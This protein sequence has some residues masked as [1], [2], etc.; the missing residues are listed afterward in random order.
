MHMF[1][2]LPVLSSKAISADDYDIDTI[3]QGLDGNDYIVCDTTPRTWQLFHDNTSCAQED[4]PLEI[5]H[6]VIK[7][8]IGNDPKLK[9]KKG[10]PAKVIDSNTV[11]TINN[12]IEEKTNNN[13]DKKTKPDKT[14]TDKTKTDKT[15]NDTTATDT[16]A[17]ATTATATPVQPKARG[18]P[19]KTNNPKNTKPR[20]PTAYNIFLQKTLKE[21][22]NLH[23]EV[24]N[25]ERMK[26]ASELWHKFKES[27]D[28]S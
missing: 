22:G 14:K 15:K 20:L 13:T 2:I 23:P 11:S 24:N 5:Y 27:E 1:T 9:K 7:N 18:R 19:R 4:T 12:K 28:A 16:T 3:C 8:D 21:L 10:R 6:F 17:T 26:M 25:K